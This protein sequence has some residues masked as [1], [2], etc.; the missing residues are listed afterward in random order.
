[1]TN[2]GTV[3][4]HDWSVKFEGGD[5]PV[6]TSSRAGE[7]VP[8]RRERRKRVTRTELLAAGRRLFSARGLYESRIEDLT[9]EA[10]IAKGTI[11]GYFA[12]KEE[13]IQAV[14]AQGF[15][16]LLLQ[17]R[18]GA[19]GARSRTDLVT[20][21]VRAH[22]EFLARNPDLMRVFHQV[23]GMLKFNRPEW[24]PLRATLRGYLAG[25]AT[26]LRAAD[27]GK[28]IPQPR[29]LELARVLFGAISGVT[30]VRAALDPVRRPSTVSAATSR[31]LVGMLLAYEAELDAGCPGSRKRRRPAQTATR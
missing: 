15:D 31:A 16:E 1:L 4:E 8:G 14:V 6:M 12:N 26:V 9:A 25:L 27:T 11:Y 19:G 3:V 23:R 2:P 28:A 7:L 18:A 22:L 20:R 17:V 10:G 13:L 30:S 24:R 21:V 29:A 5:A